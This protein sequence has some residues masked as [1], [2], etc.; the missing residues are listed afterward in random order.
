MFE[1]SSLAH[2]DEEARRRVISSLPGKRLIDPDEIA[3]LAVWLCR[4]EARLLRGAVL[5]ASLGLG[6]DPGSMRRRGT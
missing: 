5:D 3:A 1:A 2:L 4:D 6:A